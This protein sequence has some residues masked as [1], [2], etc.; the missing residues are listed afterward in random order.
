M[1]NRSPSRITLDLGPA[2]DFESSLSQVDQLSWLDEI[3]ETSSHIFTLQ[4]PLELDDIHGT[5]PTMNHSTSGA[6]PVSLTFVQS[7]EVAVQG[8]QPDSYVY[9][10]LCAGGRM[11]LGVDS[12]SRSILMNNIDESEV[13]N[14]LRMHSNIDAE[15]L[16]ESLQRNLL[17]PGFSDVLDDQ[18][19]T[20]ATKLVRENVRRHEREHIRC[21]LN[22]TTALW[23]ELH[24]YYRLLLLS[25]QLSTWRDP[26]FLN[27]T[28]FCYT[29][30][31]R[32]T[33]ELLAMLQEDYSTLEPNVRRVVKQ[34]IIDQ[35]G[36]EGDLLQ[37]I[38]RK[39]IDI[40]TLETMLRSPIGQIYC[41]IWLGY[42]I[43][44]VRSGYRLANID[45]AD[46]CRHLNI[47]LVKDN[48]GVFDQKNRKDV[49]DYMT[50]RCLGPVTELARL[51]SDDAF[52]LERAWFSMETDLSDS[53]NLL[54]V[55]RALFRR[56][57]LSYF[58]AK[59]GLDDQLDVRETAI[60]HLI[61]GSSF[62]DVQLFNMTP[63]SPAQLVDS[64]ESARATAITTLL[65]PT[66]TVAD[67][68]KWL[69]Q[70]RYGFVS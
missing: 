36:V 32:F 65:G 45:A 68:N 7:G 11:G 17:V 3:E 14:A 15:W 57:F 43:D 18:A 27:T 35:R 59:S 19:A 63:P 21:L 46:F 49:V 70:P 33:I 67:L 6:S 41:D 61:H 29:I 10:A 40:R 50:D 60:N 28:A 48:E 5:M 4:I 38:E 30:P 62:T 16:T 53:A 39:N 25:S 20:Q 22:P 23:H 58:G 24:L 1:N 51:K 66:A 13:M 56:A 64:L 52:V 55:R 47:P 34:R 54:A 69:D 26:E 12:L 31:S 37:F 8:V 44:K 42:I 9:N 2:F